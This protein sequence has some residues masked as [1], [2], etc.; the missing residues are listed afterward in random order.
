[1]VQEGVFFH[2]K[3]VGTIYFDVSTKMKKL[4]LIFIFWSAKTPQKAP[5]SGR[6]H[7]KAPKKTK[8]AQVFTKVLNT[9]LYYGPF[10]VLKSKIEVAL[11][12]LWILENKI[13]HRLLEPL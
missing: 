1:M 7:Q 8:I 2:D 10:K 6:N 13:F 11:F 5:S 3:C 4:E 9:L 12:E